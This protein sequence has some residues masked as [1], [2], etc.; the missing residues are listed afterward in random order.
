MWHIALVLQYPMNSK[1]ATRKPGD[2]VSGHTHNVLFLISSSRKGLRVG[3]VT[4]N[5]LMPTVQMHLIN[6]SPKQGTK[7]ASW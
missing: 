3:T 5:F 2:V 6:G 4:A 1:E 7:T